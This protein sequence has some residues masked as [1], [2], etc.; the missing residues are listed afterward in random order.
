GIVEVNLKRVN[1]PVNFRRCPISITWTLRY[2]YNSRK[3]LT[4]ILTEE[5]PCTMYKLLLIIGPAFTTAM[6][7]QDKR[8]LFGL[9]IVFREQDPVRKHISCSLKR[10]VLIQ[11][12]FRIGCF[13]EPLNTKPVCKPFDPLISRNVI[14]AHTEAVITAGI[15][16]Q[17]CI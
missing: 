16:M 11:T 10:F 15:H 12:Q 4:N 1:G 13:H 3:L 6:K 9:V 8:I 17:F 5:Q 14:P 2:H 7:Q